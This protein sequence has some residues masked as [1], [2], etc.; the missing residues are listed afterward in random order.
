V[1]NETLVVQGSNV[2]LSGLIFQ[3]W[4]STDRLIIRGTAGND[5]LVGSS[6]ALTTFIGGPGA[7]TLHGG[8]GGSVFEYT[9]PA[10]VQPGEVIDGGA[11]NR[12]VSSIEVAGG[13]SFDFTGATIANVSTIL[14]DGSGNTATFTSDQMAG[15]SAVQ[16]HSGGNQTLIIKGSNV[17]LSGITFRNWV[18]SDRVI[19]DGTG[20]NERI[21]GGP[22][23][24]TIDAGFGN[25][26]LTG[27]SGADTFVF[28]HALNKHIKADHITNFVHAEDK[29][30]LSQQVFGHHL[31]VNQKSFYA[32]PQ[33]THAA[34]ADDHII[35][36][37]KT[38]AL[39]YQKS[40]HAQ[41][42]EVAVLD[43]HPHI[44]FHD[45]LMVA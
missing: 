35:Y 45:F 14:F 27:G 25:N 29:I 13:F 4:A 37:K 19:L 9:T 12:A 44:N 31:K 20:S 17:N 6:Q 36:N 41:A 30:A 42:I 5:V 21:V 34:D 24:N 10:D 2:N 39:Y 16:D 8:A 3:G 18:A 11:G 28:D 26:T 32:S 7:D 40:P 33:A 38:G 43:H 23:N 22:G 1:G 15:I